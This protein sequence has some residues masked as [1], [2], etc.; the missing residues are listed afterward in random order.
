M[1]TEQNKII[2]IFRKYNLAKFCNV[3]ILIRMFGNYE[4]KKFNG[5]NY[6][7]VMVRFF[8]YCSFNSTI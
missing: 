3:N 1:L 7:D 2:F 5:L 4:T 8:L 6:H